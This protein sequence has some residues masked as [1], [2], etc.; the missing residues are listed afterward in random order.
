MSIDTILVLAVFGL[1]LFT[2]Y[3]N[4]L[5]PV[6]AFIAAVAIL[7]ISGILSPADVLH[8][9][10]NEQLAVIIMLLFFSEIIRST[11]LMDHLFTRL[12]ANTS[13]PQGFL[14]RILLFVASGSSIFNNTPL[15]A[16]TM[17]L[18]H[19]WSRKHRVSP[20]KLMIPLSYAAILGGCVTLVGTSTNLIVNGMAIESGL[21]AL[22]IFD[23]S[24]VGLPMMFVGI[25]YLLIVGMRLLPSRKEPIEEFIESSREFLVEA[26]V[27]PGSPLIGKTI[28]EAKLRHLKG[29]F[30]VEI[31]RKDHYIT[32]VSPEEILQEGDG[33]IFTGNTEALS[34]LREPALGL[35]LPQF[36][37]LPDKEN[38][39]I[40]EAVVSHNSRLADKKVQDSDFRGIWDAAILAVHRNGEKLRGKI[41]EIV[42]RPG[43]VLLLLTGPDFIPR[44][45]GAHAFYLL[46]SREDVTKVPDIKAWLVVAGIIVSLM[47]SAFNL[48]SLFTSLITLLCIALLI[49]VAPIAEIRRSMDYGLIFVLALG[50]ALGKAMINSGAAELIATQVLVFGQSFGPL[51]LLAAIFIAGNLLAS[52]ITNVAAVAILFPVSVAIAQSMQVNLVPFILIVAYSGAANFITPV[53]YQTNLMVYGPGGYTFRDFFRIGFPLTVIYG[54]AAVLILSWVYGFI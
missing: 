26:D 45:A 30:L 29:M 3:F 34:D 43:D 15:V 23:F 19:R 37:E 11:S 21:P 7:T 5:K 12:F 40:V 31:A 1:L 9:F 2:L 44:T 6:V 4:W 49:R 18:V 47:L 46:N 24:W 39:G 53:G 36:C 13:S 50:L 14:G 35:S 16:M 32:A 51:G 33:L 42:L 8:G 20:S 25:C 41:G 52:F 48:V 22:H 28:S 38:T 27:S 54:I 10:A 17:P